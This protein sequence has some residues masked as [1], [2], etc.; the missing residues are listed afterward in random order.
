MAKT[1]G[2]YTFSLRCLSI[3]AVLVRAMGSQHLMCKRSC[4]GG[5]KWISGEHG[6]A[7]L[8]STTRY[9]GDDLSWTKIK[10]KSLLSLMM[11]MH[12]FSSDAMLHQVLSSW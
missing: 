7:L 1:G 9:P 10:Y 4:E 8:S 11:M 3:I 6:E 5:K 12:P 2:V